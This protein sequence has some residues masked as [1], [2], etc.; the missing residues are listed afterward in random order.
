M[1]LKKLGK[2]DDKVFAELRLRRGAYGQRYDNGY[3]HDGQ[4]S[5][6]IPFP[7]ELTKGPDTYWHAPGM[8]RIKIPGG[9]MTAEQLE[10]M[11]DLAEEYSDAIL[12]VTTRQDIQLHF[13]HIE[14]TPDMHRRLAAVGIT[15]REACG[16]SWRNVTACPRAGVCQDEAFDVTPYAVETAWYF[17]GHR[18]VQ[19]FGRKFKPAFSG[20]SQHACGLVNMHDMGYVAKTREIDGETVRGFEVWV[21]GG[22][23]AVPHEAKLLR[24]FATEEEIIPLSQAVSRVFAR[25][26]EKKNRN[27]ARIKFLVAKLGIDEFRRLVDEELNTLEEDPRWTDWIPAARAFGEQAHPEPVEG[28]E[29]DHGPEFDRWKNTNVYQQRQKGFVGVTINLPL[30]DITSEQSRALADIV[31]KY[32]NDSIR[33]TVEQ[34]LFLRWIHEADLPALYRDLKALNLHAPAGESIADVTSCPGTDTCKL[35]ISASRGLAGVLRERLAARGLDQEPAL[36]DLRVK[37][38]GCFNSCGQHHI[39]D[40]GFFGSSRTVGNHRLPAFQLILGGQWV[41]NGGAYG[42][43][44][45]AYPSKRAPEIVDRLIDL[46]LKER[47]DGESFRDVVS[48]VGKKNVKE[49]LKDLAAPPSYEEAPEFYRDWADSREYT[50]GDIGVGE[51]AGEVVSLTEF[52]IARAESAVFDAQVLLEEDG[53]DEALRQAHQLAFQAMVL[54]AQGLLKL[55]DPDVPDDPDVIVERFRIEFYDTELFFDPYAKGKFAE[56]FFNA[57][58][59]RDEHASRDR[60]KQRIEEANLFI[61]AAIACHQ[62]LLSAGAAS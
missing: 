17:M 46:Y 55:N 11:A 24:E 30:G 40:I 60:A 21:G 52:D 43:P 33:T 51:C 22:L 37:V 25:L 45:G 7:D 14:D 2:I 19:D 8:Q 61:E 4:Q 5:R 39:A 49:Q 28:V 58:E 50:I 23:G 38:S 12:H 42:M 32:T 41:N 26:G 62:R 59:N 57:A 20:C 3:R 56:Y 31:R 6:K 13:V 10:V 48:R 44:M 36:K 9:Q 34:N 16:N 15:T 35:G 1:E 18:D 53:S 54:A 47:R 27:K 29:I